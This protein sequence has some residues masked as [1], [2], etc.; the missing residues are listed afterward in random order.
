MNQISIKEASQKLI[1][2]DDNSFENPLKSS[3]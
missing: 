3:I 1:K 2:Q